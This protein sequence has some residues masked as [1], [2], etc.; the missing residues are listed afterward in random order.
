MSRSVFIEGFGG[1][2]SSKSFMRS[3]H[4]FVETLDEH[5]ERLTVKSFSL[6]W[7]LYTNTRRLLNSQT[8]IYHIF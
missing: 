2:G 4:R 5:D 6:F 1:E 7:F 8:V 3:R